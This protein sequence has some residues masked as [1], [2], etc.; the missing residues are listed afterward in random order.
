MTQTLLEVDGLRTWFRGEAGAL[1][2]A[3]DGVGFAVRRGETLALVGESGSGK[4]VT[5]LSIM[6]LIPT[7][8]GE[9]AAGQVRFRGRDGQ[10]RDLLA[11]SERQMRRVRG[12][13]IGM[14][15]QEPMSSLNPLLDVGEQIAEVLRLH[16]GLGR[17]AARQQAG[18]MLERVHI[19]DARRRLSDYPHQMSGGMRQRVMIAIA[20]ACHPALLIADEPTT[21]LDVTIQAQVLQLLRELQAELGMGILFVTHDLGVVAEIADRVAVMYAGRIVEQGDVRDLFAAPLHP[22]TQALLHSIPSSGADTHARSRRL[23]AIAGQVPAAASL[24]PGCAFSPRCPRATAV[25]RAV[26]PPL[27]AAHPG[28]DVHCHH[29]R[30]Q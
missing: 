30:L 14:I 22:Y 20:L 24:P 29:W 25:C 11:L 5:S 12:N 28:H 21:A 15:F 26:F 1:S 17:A 27:E 18:A 19:P 2:K 8:P 6:R 7:P 23:P 10:V 3:V 4:S 9:I 16:R 13:E